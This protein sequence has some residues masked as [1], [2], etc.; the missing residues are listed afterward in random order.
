MNVLKKA[1][2]TVERG[3]IPGC[4]VA[5]GVR[6]AASVGTFFTPDL[7]SSAS[8]YNFFLVDIHSLDLAAAQ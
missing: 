6:V 7:Q 8:Q 3:A 5:R 1:G 2:F 4:A